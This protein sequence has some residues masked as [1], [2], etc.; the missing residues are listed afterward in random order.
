MA[1]VAGLFAGLFVR[2]LGL[3]LYVGLLVEA[4][5]SL[6][7]RRLPLERAERL[8]RPVGGLSPAALSDNLVRRLPQ[9]KQKLDYLV[10]AATGE[11]HVGGLARKLE[12]NPPRRIL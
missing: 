9:G 3:V 7:A 12:R 1:I 6:L 11:E 8:T 2:L 5:T 10:M 4:F